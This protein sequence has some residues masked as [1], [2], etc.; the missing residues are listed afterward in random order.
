MFDFGF[1]HNYCFQL[2][3]LYLN[4]NDLE[5]L[6]DVFDELRGLSLLLVDRNRLHALPT[7]ILQLHERITINLEHN[8]FDNEC[9]SLCDVSPCL[10]SL[11][12]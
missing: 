7:S 12:T 1:I 4:G 5:A 9:V 11:Y 6:P 3:A 10:N 8:A 2:S